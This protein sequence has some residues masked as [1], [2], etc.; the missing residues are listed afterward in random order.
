[1]IITMMIYFIR[2]VFKWLSKVITWLRLLR[3]VIGL[4]DSRQFFNQWESKSKPIAL[5]TRHFS[6][7][8]SELQVIIARSC[9]WF[10]AL[11]APVV[12]GRSNCF[13]LGF[14]TVNSKPLHPCYYFC[15]HYF[16]NQPFPWVV[17]WSNLLNCIAL[18]SPF[19]LHVWCICWC[20][21]TISS[22]VSQRNCYYLTVGTNVLLDF[23]GCREHL[24]QAKELAWIWHKSH[25]KVW[26][27]RERDEKE[28]VRTGRSANR[29]K[30][31]ETAEESSFE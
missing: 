26:Y 4:K 5:C 7:A 9:D 18:H 19:W 15:C 12:I 23:R 30:V 29:L 3:L 13:G 24:C 14:S 8:P 27:D 16:Y 6:R 10:I 17:L 25:A 22:A 11:T 20:F 2:A 28:F 1:M 21:R 31:V